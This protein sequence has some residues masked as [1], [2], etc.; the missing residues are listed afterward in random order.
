VHDA[1]S[2]VGAFVEESFA[3]AQHSFPPDALD[4]S[5]SPFADLLPLPVFACV[6]LAE[7]VVFASLDQKE[8]V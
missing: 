1:N 5:V 4:R 2:T 7:V 3:V 8:A 6:D